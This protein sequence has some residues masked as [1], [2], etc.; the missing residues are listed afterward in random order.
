MEANP[1]VPHMRIFDFRFLFDDCLLRIHEERWGLE[2]ED[3]R[4]TVSSSFSSVSIRVKICISF[5]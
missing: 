1:I 4:E 3:G 2:G 5:L